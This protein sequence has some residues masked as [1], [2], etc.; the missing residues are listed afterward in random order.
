VVLS[1]RGTTEQERA[2]AKAQ[3][4]PAPRHGDTFQKKDRIP[5]DPHTVFDRISKRA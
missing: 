3:D 1:I 5:F 4:V 2:E